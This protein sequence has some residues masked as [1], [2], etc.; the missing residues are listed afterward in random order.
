VARFDT[1]TLTVLGRARLPTGAK[2]WMLRL[3]P[4]GRQVWVQT[5]SGTNVVLDAAT[6]DHVHTETV[7]RHPVQGAFSPDGRYQLTAQL[8]EDWLAVTDRRT[9]RLIKRITVGPSAANVVFGAGGRL[10][11]VTVTGADSLVVVDMGT[12]AVIGRLKTGRAPMGLALYP[13]PRYRAAS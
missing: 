5:M 2:P 9:Y 3:S 11:Y 8:G 10:A 4:D 1:R 7:G 6:L 13:P 12:L